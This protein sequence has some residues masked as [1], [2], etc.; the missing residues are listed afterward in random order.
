MPHILLKIQACHCICRGCIPEFTTIKWKIQA[1]TC[2]PHTGSLQRLQMS[3]CSLCL[4]QNET[5]SEKVSLLISPWNLYWVTIVVV[6]LFGTKS[7]LMALVP[8]VHTGTLG[9]C[10]RHSH[11]PPGQF[12]SALK[13]SSLGANAF[14]LGHM[15][16]DM[17]QRYDCVPA[18]KALSALPGM[19]AIGSPPLPYK[20]NPWGETGSSMVQYISF[21]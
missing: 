2:L 11:P 12:G 21:P 9:M 13:R 20:K 16:R 3:I 15:A 14:G 5:N 18:R 8:N 6:N 19:C 1:N 17:W 7:Q 10:G 4:I